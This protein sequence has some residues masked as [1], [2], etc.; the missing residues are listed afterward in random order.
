MTWTKTY[1]AYLLVKKIAVIVLPLNCCVFTTLI[2]TVGK[3]LMARAVVHFEAI[4]DEG[5]FAIVYSI[6]NLN[7]M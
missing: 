4:Y 2:V 3:C 6:S 5:K 1:I 7:S